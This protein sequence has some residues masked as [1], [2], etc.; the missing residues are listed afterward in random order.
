[1]PSFNN[2]QAIIT[3]IEGTTSSISFVKDILFPYAQK[4]FASF[5][6]QHQ[7]NAEVRVQLSAVAEKC[8]IPAQ[9]TK[10][11][12]QQLLN[13]IKDDVK[14]TPLKNLQGMIWKKGYQNGDYKA[15]MYPDAVDLLKEW[16]KKELPLYVYSS[17][18]V[19]AQK[20]FFSHSSAGDLLPLFAGHFDTNIGAKQEALSYLNI[21]NALGIDA[22]NLLFL[23][24][25]S[26]ELDAARQAGFQTCH[27]I[28]NEQAAK[29]N[30]MSSD[31]ASLHPEVSSFQQITLCSQIAI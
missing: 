12:I 22:K 27:V 11:I 31:S 8:N 19:L 2:I 26:Q 28:R 29:Q 20:L 15:H 18:S 7:D 21:Q 30:T 23:S 9:D 13:W 17:G 6:K 5:I 14:A 25:I 10:Q 16:N 3:D 24:D 1:M 4:H